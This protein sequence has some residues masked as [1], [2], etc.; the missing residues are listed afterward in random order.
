MRSE[1]FSAIVVTHYARILHHLK[2]DRVHVMVD[3]TIVESGGPALALELEENGYAK[4]GVQEE[5]SP[6]IALD[7]E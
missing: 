4:F 2:P 3:G 7:V 1:E 5:K 6:T